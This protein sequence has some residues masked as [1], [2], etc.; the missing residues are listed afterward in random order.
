VAKDV[1]IQVEFNPAAVSAYRLIGYEKRL[2]QKEDFN[3]DKKDAGEMGAGHS[4]TALY[5]IVPAGV[6]VDLPFVD[7][8]KYQPQPA[9][10]SAS[11]S[12]LMTV[13]IRYKEPDG[14]TSRLMTVAVRNRPSEASPR[15]GFAAGAREHR[16]PHTSS[17]GHVQFCRR[18]GA[19][20]D[21][22]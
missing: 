6:P 5:E 4:V 2:L 22:S 19:T 21:A 7:P 18:I 3:D 15:L 11:A 17:G 1:K 20:L 9:P 13:K 10:S 14:E 8:L 16:E 12:E